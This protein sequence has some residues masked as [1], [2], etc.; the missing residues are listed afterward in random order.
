MVTLTG[1]TA[2]HST[3]MV[4]VKMWDEAA[5]LLRFSLFHKAD[6]ILS[7]TLCVKRDTKTS[8]RLRIRLRVSASGCLFLYLVF[9]SFMWVVSAT[10]AH[11][12][13]YMRVHTRACSTEHFEFIFK[14][15][16]H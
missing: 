8:I 1:V 3:R 15:K 6:A 5:L 12:P 14:I 11:K 16:R 13:T 9:V 2:R 7:E 10:S 4:F